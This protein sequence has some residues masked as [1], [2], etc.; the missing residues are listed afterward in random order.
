MLKLIIAGG[1][2]FRNY[3]LLQREVDNFIQ[4]LMTSGEIEPSAEME[5]VS[6]KQVT[7]PKPYDKKTWHG[8]DYLGELY[9]ES[10]NIPVKP[11]PAKWDRYGRSAGHIRNEEMAQYGEALIAFWDGSSPGTKSMIELAKQYGLISRVINY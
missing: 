6:G 4:Y 2:D 7:K 5:I 9:A 1:R 11:F 8:A 10:Y 3:P